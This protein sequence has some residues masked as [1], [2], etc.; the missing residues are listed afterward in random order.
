MSPFSKPLSPQDFIT[1]IRHTISVFQMLKNG[2]SVLVGVS[3][4]PDS[5]AL[6]QALVELSKTCPM[7]L[8]VAHLNHGLRGEES[9]SDEAFVLSSANALGLPCYIEK[10]SIFHDHSSKRISIEE[11]GREARYAFF[12]QVADREGFDKIA[13]GHHADDT[14]EIILIN[15]IRG[16]GPSGLKG[17]PSVRGKIIRPLIGV[18]REL[19]LSY[20]KYNQIKYRIDSSNADQRFVRNKIRHQLLP[21]L[22][23]QYNPNISVALNR[24]GHLLSTE[25][26]WLS[27]YIDQ[28][29]EQCTHSKELHCI[30]LYIEK[31]QKLHLSI[32]RRVIR[33]SI[34][35]VKCDLRRISFAHVDAVMDLFKHDSK[36]LQLDLPDRIRIRTQKGLVLITKEKKNLRSSGRSGKTDRPVCFERTILASEINESPIII[37]ERNLCLKFEKRNRKDIR[38]VTVLSS[39]MAFFDWDRL[40]FPLKVRNYRPGD[41]FIPLGMTGRQPLKKFFINNKISRQHRLHVPILLSENKIIWVVGM[42]ISDYVKVTPETKT[43][44]CAEM[45]LG[46][47]SLPAG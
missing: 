19:I 22:K 43:V 33:R 47:P 27:Q 39:D 31:L 29:L 10:K 17:I 44:L 13:V 21:I 5:I 14:A 24:L 8:G 25:E 1:R 42:R 36:D 12:N 7:R 6:L 11:A 18:S 37:K 16:S 20:L 3:G 30:V 28:A 38:D 15:L 32:Q 2:D 45:V 41:S 4:G 9:D 46:P 35:H 23:S 34:C 40:T 26:E